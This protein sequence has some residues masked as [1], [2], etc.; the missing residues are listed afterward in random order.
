MFCEHLGFGQ[1]SGGT[2]PSNSGLSPTAG[3]RLQLAPGGAVL[4]SKF[5]VT[6]LGNEHFMCCVQ[7]AL[8]SFLI[9]CVKCAGTITA[10]SL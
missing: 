4:I 2:Q 3:H 7:E 9:M 5:G 1:L 10:Q 6:H 8:N